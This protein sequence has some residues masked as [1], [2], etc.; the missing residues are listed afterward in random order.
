MMGQWSFD[1]CTRTR[2][3]STHTS[4]SC[5][6]LTHFAILMSSAHANVSELLLSPTGLLTKYGGPTNI[7]CYFYLNLLNNFTLP[8]KGL[9]SVWFIYFF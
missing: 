9:G 3:N 1:G 8:F 7:Y 6:H 2:V 4:C 5:N